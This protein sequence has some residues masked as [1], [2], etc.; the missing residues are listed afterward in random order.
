MV[1]RRTLRKNRGELYKVFEMRDRSASRM[2]QK[3]FVELLTDF[4]KRE[5]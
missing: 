2:K 5:L 1:R 4:F 3:V